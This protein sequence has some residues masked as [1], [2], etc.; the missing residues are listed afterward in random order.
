M[1]NQFLNFVAFASFVVNTPMQ[2]KQHRLH[3]GGSG[4]LP[5]S[6]L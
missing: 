6:N 4:W 5:P 1:G 2:G 3:R